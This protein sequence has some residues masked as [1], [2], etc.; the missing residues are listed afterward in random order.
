MS[1]AMPLNLNLTQEDA[2][3]QILPHPPLF[4]SHQ[5]GW[6]DIHAQHHQQP[7]GEIPK[8]C[9]PHHVIVVHQNKQITQSNRIVDGKKKSEQ[10]I[11]GDIEIIPSNVHYQSSWVRETEFTLVFLNPTYVAQI[12]YE[13]VAPDNIEIVPRF[14]TPD[15]LIYQIGLSLK[16]E[17]ESKE[18]RSR[19]YVDSLKTTLAIILLRHYS[20]RKLVNQNY[21][22]GLSKSELRQVI[23][24]INDYLAEDLSLRAIAAVI[25]MSPYHFTRL[26][27]QSTGFT[28]HQYVI[29]RR[30]EKAKQLL[31]KQKLSIVEVS[32]QVGFES[33]SHFTKVFRKYTEMPPKTYREA[34]IPPN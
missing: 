20:A 9:G 23:E 32:Q 6:E 5:L 14:V 16:L 34:S 22:G 15:P 29:Q 31:I 8:V 25:Q 27:K 24:Y 26:F 19:L 12:A 7:A 2:I 11:N 13:S 33:Q 18:L 17:L 3:S 4:S 10:H 30:I 1:E 28:P 21:T